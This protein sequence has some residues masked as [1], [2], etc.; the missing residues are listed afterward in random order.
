MDIE[1]V[2]K[3]LEEDVD[4]AFELFKQTGEVVNSDDHP[5]V[6]FQQCGDL[7]E[8]YAGSRN[9]TFDEAPKVVADVTAAIQGLPDQ[10][11]ESYVQRLVR[12]RHFFNTE[13]E[14]HA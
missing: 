11:K 2:L 8:Q 14:D 4:A 5:G 1:G 3:R 10:Q 6:Q 12:V 9:Y 13:R 7:I